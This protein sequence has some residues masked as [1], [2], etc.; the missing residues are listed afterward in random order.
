M[1]HGTAYIFQQCL[2]N[3]AIQPNTSGLLSS[4]STS[5]FLAPCL[6]TQVFPMQKPSPTSTLERT[7]WSSPATTHQ[8]W[9]SSWQRPSRSQLRGPTARPCFFWTFLLQFFSLSAGPQGGER[10]KEGPGDEAA[11]KKEWTAVFT[12]WQSSQSST[13]GA[14]LCWILLG[15]LPIE[16][17][18]QYCFLFFLSFF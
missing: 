16:K 17:R 6:V 7:L 14:P 13:E 10:G 9:V 5:F 12:I 8:S 2:C 3:S 4:L 11:P 18:C 15:L 1:K